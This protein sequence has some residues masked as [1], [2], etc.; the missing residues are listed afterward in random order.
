[1]IQ[2][3]FNFYWYLSKNVYKN[4]FL[5]YQ[6]LYDLFYIHTYVINIEWTKNY[7]VWRSSELSNCSLKET[8]R[9]WKFSLTL[10]LTSLAETSQIGA[11]GP[12]TIYLSSMILTTPLLHFTEKGLSKL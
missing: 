5:F 4:F 6:F 1:M 7:T 12:V 2:M 8:H 9:G 3:S 10:L 11:Q